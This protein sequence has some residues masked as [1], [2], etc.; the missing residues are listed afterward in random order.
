MKIII[1]ILCF[2]LLAAA[3]G[4]KKKVTN[5]VPLDQINSDRSNNYNYIFNDEISEDR[6]KA[7]QEKKKEFRD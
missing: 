4:C 1:H 7:E 3:Q 5:K 2:L 6:K